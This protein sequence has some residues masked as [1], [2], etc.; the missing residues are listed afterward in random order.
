VI[1]TTHNSALKFYAYGNP[2]I[3]CGAMEFDHQTLAPTYRLRIGVPGSS[4]AFE[5]AKRLGLDEDIIADARRKLD[6]FAS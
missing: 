6:E 3:E 1:V 2:E 4:Y 5:I